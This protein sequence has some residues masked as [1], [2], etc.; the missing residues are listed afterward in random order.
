MIININ[1]TMNVALMF[2]MIQSKFSYAKCSNTFMIR[3][4]SR[5]HADFPTIYET[6]KKLK[7]SQQYTKVSYNSRINNFNLR[8]TPRN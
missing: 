3:N 5:Y 2:C 8:V 6:T 1:I 4:I 7:E